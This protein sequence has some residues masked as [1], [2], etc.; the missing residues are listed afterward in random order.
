MKVREHS[1]AQK[2]QV[3]DSSFLVVL[4]FEIDRSIETDEGRAAAPLYD[5]ERFHRCADGTSFA[6]CAGARTPLRSGTR[7]LM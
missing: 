4:Y 2:W 6:S 7:S 3:V 1:F 5:T